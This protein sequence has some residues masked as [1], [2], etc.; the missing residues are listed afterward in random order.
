MIH[1]HM[2]Y[3]IVCVRYECAGSSKCGCG[4]QIWVC[5]SP[6]I[7]STLDQGVCVCVCVMIILVF[8]LMKDVIDGIV[9]LPILN[10]ILQSNT[11]TDDTLYHWMYTH[12]YVSQYI[13]HTYGVLCLSTDD[14][15]WNGIC[16]CDV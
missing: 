2:I 3:I 11:A 13:I 4:G 6:C 9:A 7:I 5:L 16:L 8:A 14:T 1:V 15:G 12:R 10:S